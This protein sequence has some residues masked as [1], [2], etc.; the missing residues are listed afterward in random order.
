MSQPEHPHTRTHTH[1]NKYTY[2][3]KHLNHPKTLCKTHSG[4]PSPEK[5]VGQAWCSKFI[6]ASEGFR[7]ISECEVGLISWPPS[8]GPTLHAG[9]PVC[10]PAG[11]A[12]MDNLPRAPPPLQTPI[13]KAVCQPHTPGY[14]LHDTPPP[15]KGWAS[16]PPTPGPTCPPPHGFWLLR[17]PLPA[18]WVPQAPQAGLLPHTAC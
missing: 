6:E 4:S 12:H 17:L 15:P 14:F 5:L 13:A 2:T 11:R 1:T 18:A 10:P 9:S 8:P 3:H 16:E 7:G